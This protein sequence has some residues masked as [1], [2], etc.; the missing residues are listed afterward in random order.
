MNHTLVYVHGTNGSGKSTLARS[1]AAA[2]G[3]VA[4][5]I[6]YTGQ[7]PDM[8]RDVRVKA[9]H[10]RTPRGVALLGK[11]GSAC[12]GVD[13]IHPYAMVKEVL[14][15]H[16]IFPQARV[17]AEGL[18]TPGVDTCVGFAGLFR[19]AVFIHLD[20]P[21]EQCL[22]NVLAR[23]ARA[24]KTKG[25]ELTPYTGHDNLTKKAQ[26][27]AHWADRLEKAG[28]TV[29]RLQ[30]PEAREKCLELLGLTNPSI[31]ELL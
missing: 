13:G 17:F 28:L 25:K 9:G 7:P 4:E 8:H 20:T 6:P 19:Q 18:I 16:A 14:I 26:S 1:V 29:L 22:E 2:A 21:L 15:R 12:G 23:R 30:Y 10:T 27:A 31:E 3:G 5:Y 11:Y 24:A